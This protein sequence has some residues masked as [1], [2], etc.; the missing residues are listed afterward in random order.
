ML[1][2]IILSVIEII[3]CTVPI[4]FCRTTFCE[5]INAVVVFIDKAVHLHYGIGAYR[6]DVRRRKC[7][8]Y[9]VQSV[10]KDLDILECLSSQRSE[11][12]LPDVAGKTGLN[13]I[14]AKATEAVWSK[15]SQRPVTAY[16]TNWATWKYD[17]PEPS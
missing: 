14:T 16:P 8:S 7:R 3:N 4:P 5:F 12:D 15:G 17:R 1:I 2:V 6:F 13:R 11:L 10:E 9:R